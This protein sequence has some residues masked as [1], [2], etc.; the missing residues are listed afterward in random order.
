MTK[1][2]SKIREEV[3]SFSPW[4]RIVCVTF[5]VL[6]IF[7]WFTT[8]YIEGVQRLKNIEPRLP[9]MAKDSIEYIKLSESLISEHELTFDGRLE[10][11]RS[12]AYP[13]FV[14]VI[15]TLGGSYFAVTLI[16]II[17]LFLSVFM[18]RRIGIFF[19]NKKVG[20]I[21]GAL[22]LINPVSMTLSL[23]ILT[24]V[25]FMFV[26]ITGFYIAI[27]LKEKEFFK[28][29]IIVSILFVLAIYVRS[30]GLFALPIFIA[31]FL[32][33]KV[34]FKIQLKSIGI[35]AIIVIL[36]VIPWVLRNY[37]KTG[38]AGFNSFESVQFTWAIPKFLSTVDHTKEADESV[39]FRIA[40]GVSE[41]EW[42]NRGLYDIRYSKQINAVGEKILLDRP[43]EYLK[44][45][46]TTSIP[47]L[48]P[49]SI[50]FIR[51]ASD[52]ALGINRPFKYGAI[53]ALAAGDIKSFLRDITVD[54]W[55]IGERLLWLLGIVFGVVALWL[56]RREKLVWVFVFIPAYL[57]F[58]SGPAAGPRL[59]FQAWP[60]M[61]MLFIIGGIEFV[62]FCK[63]WRRFKI[64]K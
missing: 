21:A 58:L 44:W 49:S 11:L 5:A 50:L 39:K 32:A 45:H 20:E 31:P 23:L 51:D 53:N 14:G 43:F 59:S 64:F 36:S 8:V 1:I 4:F 17:L 6:Y 29:T 24:D 38:V 16:Q 57:M 15:K 55:K 52:A 26:F 61:F 62:G 30:M 3:R 48:F 34:S 35:M 25:L 41:E 63:K 13:L 54:W 37:V 60:F 7:L 2:F 40:T 56:N 33:S 9:G 22:L 12:P 27:S 47:F 19:R 42:N 10:T 18:V 46:I 28:R